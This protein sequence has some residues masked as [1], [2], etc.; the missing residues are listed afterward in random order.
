MIMLLLEKIGVLILCIVYLLVF[1]ALV[2]IFLTGVVFVTNCLKA[3]VI[4]IFGK[5]K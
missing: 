1:F 5:K 3:T 2:Y 4:G